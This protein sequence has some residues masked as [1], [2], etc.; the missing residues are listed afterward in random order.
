MMTPRSASLTQLN[1]A[2]LIILALIFFTLSISASAVVFFYPLEIETRESTVWL[3]VLAIE[4]DINIYDHSQV[5]FINMFH[6]PFDPLFKF[7]I[8][9]LFPF[10][11]SWQVTRFA[12]FILPYFF[13]AVAW[14]LIARYSREPVLHTIY[15]G[16]I[17]YLF[18][19]VSAKE[20]IFVGRSDAT[21]AVFLLLLIFVSTSF[22]PKTALTAG[23][24]GFLC[25]TIG[26]S[27][28]LTN[29]RVAPSILAILIFTLWK[30]RYIHLTTWRLTFVHLMSFSTASVGISGVILY[31]IFDFNL[32]LYYKLFFGFFTE[33]SGWG[34]TPY[35]HR[36]AIWF[37]GS[38]FKPTASPDSLKG[39]PLILAL[40]VYFLVSGWGEREKKGWVLLGCLVF[41]S[42]ALAY[43]LNYYGGGSWYFIPFL[44]VLWFF[45]CRSYPKMSESRLALLGII[46]LALLCI[47]IRTVM[48]PTLS[49]ISTMRKAHDFMA[50]VRS[51]EKTNVILSEDTFFF[52]TS[53]QGELIDMG[54][55]IAAVHKKGYYGDTF[56]ATVNDHFKKMQRHPPDY[57]L[58]GFTESPELNKLIEAKYTLILE[59]PNNLTA[60]GYGASKLFKRRD[61]IT[62]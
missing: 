58:T 5:A 30:Y 18:L 17:G 22:L 15:I 1:R 41:V 3:H 42:C 10:L 32:R 45:C 28:I 57:I 8:A 25:G 20:F 37:L 12:V 47:N 4:E 43:Y 29:W 2:F 55:T 6:G 62:H 34:S 33:S 44:I 26:I 39:G 24:H 31:Y 19:L 23:L 54:D 53:Y 27:A 59:G 51:L 52:R 61:L 50:E 21:A 11:Q 35:G 38:L 9:T 13:L 49:R 14:R 46:M 7:S 16:S 36:P 56:N 40:S 60:N 48:V